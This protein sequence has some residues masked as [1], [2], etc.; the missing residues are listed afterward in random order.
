MNSDLE[1]TLD[2]LQASARFRATLQKKEVALCIG[3]GKVRIVRI[4]DIGAE[5]SKSGR[6]DA[7]QCPLFVIEEK[8]FAEYPR[9]LVAILGP[10]LVTHDEDGRS[11]AFS[12]TRED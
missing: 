12:V 5:V 7:N 8:C 10:H 6:H 1:L 9:I 4:P 11:A 3:L 2:I